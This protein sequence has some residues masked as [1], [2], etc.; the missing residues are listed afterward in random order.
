MTLINQSESDKVTAEC[1]PL[2]NQSPQWQLAEEVAE[3]VGATEDL[4]IEIWFLVGGDV[5]LSIKID[6]IFGSVSFVEDRL[7]HVW[8]TRNGKGSPPWPARCLAP[9]DASCALAERCFETLLGE[10][11]ELLAIKVLH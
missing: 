7:G 9:D 10:T 6:S 11:N 8:L 2:A 5:Q 4:G 1:V 3:I